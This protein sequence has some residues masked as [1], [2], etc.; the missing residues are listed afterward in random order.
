MAQQFFIGGE[1]V[2]GES[3]EVAEVWNP[4]TEE[5]V[6]RV[7]Q[8][9][10][11]DARRALDAAADAQAAWEDVPASERAKLLVRWAELIEENLEAIAPLF[12]STVP[13]MVSVYHPNSSHKD[14]RPRVRRRILGAQTNAVGDQGNEGIEGASNPYAV[15]YR[16]IGKD[17]YPRCPPPTPW[18]RKARPRV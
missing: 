16:Y 15:R 11:E 6:D 4:A 2:D 5:L 7:P 12:R 9:T 10:R 13:S 14:H 1:W 8:G 18:Q 17:Y 3:G